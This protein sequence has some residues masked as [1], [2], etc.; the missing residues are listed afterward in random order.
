LRKEIPMK[1]RLITVLA[2]V[3]L[4]V[5]AG[6]GETLV[7]K[8]Q[9]D[10]DNYNA[11]ISIARSL[12][13]QGGEI[14]LDI[15]IQGMKDELTGERHIVTED[16]VSETM[17]ASQN[18]LKQKQVCQ[19]IDDPELYEAICN[20]TVP[21]AP[22]SSQ[23]QVQK[24][25]SD[26]EQTFAALFASTPAAPRRIASQTGVLSQAL[27]QRQ[28]P[29]QYQTFADLQ[30]AQA[31]VNDEPVKIERSDLARRFGEAWLKTQPHQ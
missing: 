23:A 31:Q 26:E 8:T 14:N 25:R 15:V 27:M 12:R 1:L 24:Q 10:K 9:K 22:A 11:G 21:Q 19:V 3:L 17:V 18:E 28:A 30:A 29:V 2:I 5:Q 13:Q 4:A 6:A 20:R 16:N 7:L